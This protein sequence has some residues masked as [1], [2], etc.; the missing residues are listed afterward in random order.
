MQVNAWLVIATVGFTLLIVLFDRY[1]R[2][3]RPFQD[4]AIM[5]G[6]IY[7]GLWDS[8]QIGDWMAPMIEPVLTGSFDD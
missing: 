3:D 2:L 7:I 5:N 8:S 6:V 4:Y 1:R